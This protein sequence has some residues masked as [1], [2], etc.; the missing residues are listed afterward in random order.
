MRRRRTA[1]FLRR[2]G[3]WAFSPLLSMRP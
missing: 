1:D 2:Y 3:A